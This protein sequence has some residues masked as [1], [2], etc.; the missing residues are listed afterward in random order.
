MT[1]VGRPVSTSLRLV[2][3][4]QTALPEFRTRNLLPTRTTLGT[5]GRMD[6]YFDPIALPAHQATLTVRKIDGQYVINGSTDDELGRCIDTRFAPCLC[7][8]PGPVDPM[9]EVLCNDDAK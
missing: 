8:A 2:T 7:C 1:S 4:E 9:R 5:I 3:V 6:L